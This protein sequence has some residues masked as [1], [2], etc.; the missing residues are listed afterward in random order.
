MPE[1]P[2]PYFTPPGGTF[3]SCPSVTI[4]CSD[5]EAAIYY[6]TDG[7]NPDG[8]S[9]RYESP[10]PILG[11]GTA[12]VVKAMAKKDG[13]SPSAIVAETYRIE[14]PE[15]LSVSAGQTH[16]LVIKAD[17]SLWA[18]GDNAKGQLGDGTTTERHSPVQVMAG[19]KMAVAGRQA[20][21]A[22]KD[23]GSLW[24]FGSGLPFGDNMGDS[25][26]TPKWIMDGV[27][28]AAMGT[29]HLLILKL[30]H[31]LWAMGYNYYYQ[32]GN[33][34]QQ[35][36]KT[37]VKI[38]DDVASMA[39]GFGHS[40]A[41]LNDGTAWGWGDNREQVIDNR[42]DTSIP[43]PVSVF[44]DV[45]AV[46]AGGMQSLFLGKDGSLWLRGLDF[47]HTLR[48]GVG[49]GGSNTLPA[50]RLC[51]SGVRTAVLTRYHVL[52][53]KTD[54]TLWGF[55]DNYYAQLGD[56]TPFSSQEAV[57]IM[58]AVQAVSAG[59]RHSLLI[60]NDGSLWAMG[61]NTYGQLGDGTT[62]TW[63][64]PR[65]IWFDAA[66]PNA[67]GTGPTNP[68]FTTPALIPVNRE[69][70]EYQDYIATVRTKIVSFEILEDRRVKVNAQWTATFNSGSWVE[71]L[72]DRNNR[73]MFLVDDLGRKYDHVDVGGAAA[74]DTNLR[75]GIPVTGWYMFP[76][77]DPHATQ[78]VF[79]ILDN[80]DR[81]ITLYP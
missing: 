80:G 10:I 4:H 63:L 74:T 53:I 70:R 11:D 27:L 44:T 18:F 81:R 8:T 30:D 38:L 16:S 50:P 28:S 1:T 5:S 49:V 60:R 71:K 48:G 26:T 31:S 73:E 78:L 2:A 57:R 56:G 24:G 15:T 3:L 7:R 19:V 25:I 9:P 65:R 17:G 39:G 51:L 29:D 46:A 59:E 34:S 55:G 58:D 61:D 41:V 77:I 75:N 45:M 47:L 21:I 52:A 62:E 54:D 13:L 42:P 68:L 36:Q 14:Y 66:D 22:L 67:M 79:F 37:P 12:T 33:G 76:P 72:S 35:F 6:T 20:S 32:L 43:T 40:L 64:R 69:I 23:D